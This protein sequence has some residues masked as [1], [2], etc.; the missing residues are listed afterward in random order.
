MQ[1]PRDGAFAV[2]RSLRL[3]DGRTWGETA[4]EYQRR[5]ALSILDTGDPVRQTWLTLPRGG[6]KTTD[7]AGILIAVL[8]VQ[9]PAMSRSYV[10][11]SDADQ[12][13]E[14]IDAAAGLIARTDE[15]AQLFAVNELVITNRVTGASLTALPADS[16]AMGKRAYFLILDEVGNW[17]ETRK[18]RRFWGTLT[19]GN[20]KIAECRTVVATNAS[21]PEH[22]SAQ[23]RAVALNSPHWRVFE[24]PGPL[25]WL[26]AADIEVLR[27]NSE[28]PSEFERLHL[29]RW[30]SAEDRLA[31]MDDII[32]CTRLPETPS[33]MPAPPR[34][35]PL[36]AIGVDMATTRDNAVV[37]VAHLVDDKRVVV[38]DVK[39]WTPRPGAPVPHDEVEQHI[40]VMWSEYRA[41]VVFD[42]AEFRGAAQRLT[43]VGV[44]VEQFTFTQASVGKLALTLFNLLRDHEV[45]LPR[46][47]ALVD[48]LAT[49][50]LL[51]PGPGLWRLDHDPSRHD[52]RV[53]ALALAAQWLLEH[54]ANRP[55]WVWPSEQPAKLVK[56]LPTM[57][58]LQRAWS[59]WSW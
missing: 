46:D 49:V 31:S 14:L 15:V 10:G 40:A 53:I 26:T 33:R 28:T 1:S 7:L 29:N 32:A 57:A 44:G 35:G 59:G 12:A 55:S 38:D 39:V 13:R 51:H 21:F 56:G 45:A 54:G 19:S 3:E 5:H 30:V 20:R 27:E 58:D 48:E 47:D 34:S 16:S 17:P 18:A 37:V 43:A 11:A 52:D 2:L 24:I 22:W 25:P 4:V 42:P 36:Y 8:A 9:A 41:A 6:R 50:R 23:R